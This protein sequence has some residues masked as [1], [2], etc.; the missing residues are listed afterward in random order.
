MVRVEISKVQSGYFLACDAIHSSGRVLCKEGTVLTNDVINYIISSSNESFVVCVESFED[1]KPRLSHDGVVASKYISLI[2]SQLSSYMNVSFRKGE[3]IVKI[4]GQL[5]SYLLEHRDILQELITIRHIHDYTYN[6]CLNV[7]IIACQ[8]GVELGLTESEIRALVLGSLL[9]DLGK[10]D[11][12][13]EI[14]DKPSKLSDDEFCTIKQHPQFGCDLLESVDLDDRAHAIVIQHH[15]KL[16]GTG[17]PNKLHYNKIHDL[18]KIAAVADIF[19]AVTSERSYH[20]PMAT[21]KAV[22]LLI[23]DAESGKVDKLV[24]D[25]LKECVV[26]YPINTY[27]TLSNGMSGFVVDSGV[28]NMPV[29]FDI[30]CKRYF[31]LAKHLDV[32]VVVG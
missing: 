29:I 20:K 26:M 27:L 1:V 16:D 28:N 6:H 32:Q 18:S 8:I 31:N 17:Y 15:E 23:K 12:P 21:H 7:A 19:D 25:S 11:I 2:L 4:A 24:V 22:D 14:L 5:S 13:V 30:Q 10:I 9:H 3:S